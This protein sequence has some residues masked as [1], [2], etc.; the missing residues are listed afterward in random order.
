MAQFLV[1]FGSAQKSLSEFR[2][3]VDPIVP[4]EFDKPAP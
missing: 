1:P 4:V 2:S 3:L